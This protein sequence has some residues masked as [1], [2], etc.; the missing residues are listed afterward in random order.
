MQILPN[1]EQGVFSLAKNITI[2]EGGIAKNFTAS[3]LRTKLTGTDDTCSWIPED[4]VLNYVSLGEK[5]IVANGTY[6]ASADNLNGFSKVTVNIEGSY[7]EE[8]IY[9]QINI[10]EFGGS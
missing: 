8:L 1:I 4:E 9:A 10:Y 7:P 3:K 5:T 6:T 2:E